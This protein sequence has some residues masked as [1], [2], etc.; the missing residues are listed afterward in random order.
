MKYERPSPVEDDP[1]TVRRRPAG[2]WIH[3]NAQDEASLGL[4]VDDG[5]SAVRAQVDGVAEGERLQMR[6]DPPRAAIV[7]EVPD[8]D[9]S[10]EL[11]VAVPAAPLVAHLHQPR[12][13]LGRWPGDGYGVSC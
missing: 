6:D 13:H 7:D 9:R 5:K 2:Q 3:W 1:G 10:F 4:Q 8:T 11:V 12:P